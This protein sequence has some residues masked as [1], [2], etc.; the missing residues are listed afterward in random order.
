MKRSE[1]KLVIVLTIIGALAGHLSCFWVLPATGSNFVDSM[2]RTLTGGGFALIAS[3][4]I[5]IA[6]KKQ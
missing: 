2:P 1:W 4:L 5:V 3:L 6:S